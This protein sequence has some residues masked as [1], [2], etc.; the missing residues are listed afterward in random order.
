VSAAGV[1]SWSADADADGHDG[2]PMPVYSAVRRPE[3]S[4]GPPWGPAPRP[5]G[6]DTWASG[7]PPGWQR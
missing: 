6:P 3:V 4:G 7:S 5:P 1:A 2:A